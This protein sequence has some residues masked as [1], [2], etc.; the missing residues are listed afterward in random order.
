MEGVAADAAAPFFFLDYPPFGGADSMP[1]RIYPFPL[2][3]ALVL[4]TGL[5]PHPARAQDGGGSVGGAVVG[6]LAGGVAGLLGAYP[7]TG[8]PLAH[9]GAAGDLDSCDVASVTLALGG[10][11]AGAW[12]GAENDGAGY[13]IGLGLLAGFGTGLLVGRLLDTP[14]WLDAGLILAGAVAGGIIGGRDD[15]GADDPTAPASEL[16][17][18]LWSLPVRF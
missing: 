10:T 4:M 2:V 9:F 17:L 18:S 1:T 11:A 3:L 13:G 15:G 7:L 6:G 5:L 16:R 14:R 12:I 8:C